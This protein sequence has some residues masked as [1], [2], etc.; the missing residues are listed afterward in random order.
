MSKSAYTEKMVAELNARP[1]WHYA[2]AVAYAEANALKPRSVIAKVKSLGLSYVP[3]PVVTKA[4]EPIERKAEIV[5]EIA[6]ALNVNAES[7]KS[8]AKM[9]KN[10]L[11]ALRKAVVAE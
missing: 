10:E 3:K 6:A 2:E 7:I 5:A 9:A 4:G 11:N 8:M 1:V